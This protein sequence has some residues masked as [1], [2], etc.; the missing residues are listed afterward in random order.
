M[1]MFQIERY[2]SN[3]GILTNVAMSSRVELVAAA[4]DLWAELDDGGMPEHDEGEVLEGVETA[5]DRL[6]SALKPFDEV[7]V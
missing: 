7:E 5:H 3:A 4:R 1:G 2:V 6:R